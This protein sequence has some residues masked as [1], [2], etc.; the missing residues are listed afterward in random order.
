MKTS[1]LS[2]LILGIAMIVTAWI[3]GNAFQ[4]RNSK[5]DTISVTGL[6][7]KDFT[8][9]QIFWSGH[10]DTKAVDA[11]DAYNKIISDREK[12]KAF[13]LSKGFTEKEFTFAG[14]ILDK[15]YK[16]ITIEQN[17]EEKKTEQVFDG[18]TASQTVSF[19]SDKDSA[20]MK[21]IEAVMD[22]TSELINSG[23]QFNPN[24]AQYTYSD[25]PSLKHN[26]IENATRDARERAEKIVGTGN[27][28]LGK[29]KMATMGVFQI[30]AKGSTE[31]DTYGGNFDTYSKEKTARITVRLT[32]ELD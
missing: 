14:V 5:Q 18:Y 21:K 29:L 9:D 20:L 10:F 27:G 4:N 23:I 22:Q 19:S 26:L 24:Q 13:F 8:S 31:E 17:G 12:V 6:G 7:T 2:A 3:L 25:L 30:T 32:Y 16:T 28:K 15:T 11:K 1:F